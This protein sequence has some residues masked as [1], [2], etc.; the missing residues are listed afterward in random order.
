M[1]PKLAAM[2]HVMKQLHFLSFKLKCL[3]YEFYHSIVQYMENMGVQPPWVCFMTFSSVIQSQIPC[4]IDMTSLCILYTS[5]TTSSNWNMADTAMLLMESMWQS[6]ENWPFS[7]MP[8]LTL[9]STYLHTGNLLQKISSKVFTP[10]F[11]TIVWPTYVYV[12]WIYRL[13]LG[14]NA[15]FQLKRKKVLSKEHNPSLNKG[16]AFFVEEGEYKEH[17][18]KHWT[19]K[20][21]VQVLQCFFTSV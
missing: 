8:V 19:Q 1:N 11:L 10:L 3:G 14:I 16:W 15:N 21:E 5:G 7:A 9:A 17:L 13:F 4:R 6:L 12:R 2:F 18:A 20:Q